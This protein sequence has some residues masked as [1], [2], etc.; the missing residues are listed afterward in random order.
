[1]EVDLRKMPLGNLSKRH[2][3][4]GYEVL[5]NIEKT[6]NNDQL[7]DK[8]RAQELLGLTNQFYTFIPHD[9]GTN[10]ITIIDSAE[11]LK[12]KMTLMEALIDIEIATTLMKQKGEGDDVES[13]I[14]INY[15]K[16]K[17]EISPLEK[18]GKEWD[19]VK[20]YVSNQQGMYSLELID[21]YKID[22][23]GEDEQ[24][25]T[26]AKMGNRQLL[27][28]G[29]RT[30]NYVGILSQGLRIAPP[31]APKSGYRFGKGIYFADICEKSAG[32]CRGGSS[33][34][35]LMMLVEVS[36]GRVKE[37][38]SDQYMEKPLPGSDSTKALGSIAPDKQI[39][40]EN[41][42]VLP[43]GKPKK[44][45]VKSSCS[46]NEYIIYSK[47]QACIRYLLKLTIK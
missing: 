32:Y 41:G 23:E 16:L 31:E 27:W 10:D 39:T 3:K 28:H 36:L 21:A 12:T 22:R 17:C 30:T 24:F 35:I 40:L 33:D 4:S 14:D 6:L 38:Y 18:K 37:L 9:F 46:H 7:D 11:V 8:K 2:V 45:G 26:S 42:T 13:P 1:M 15:K 34:V 5:K 20:E 25:K 44:T 47:P 29:S 43:L 19:L